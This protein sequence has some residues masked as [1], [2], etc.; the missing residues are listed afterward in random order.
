[1]APIHHF[2]GI[3]PAPGKEA[4]LKEVMT[5]FADKVEKQE[6]GVLKFH[7]FEQF[8]GEK[9]NVII[10]H[11]VYED[12]AAL[13]AHLKTEHFAAVKKTFAEEGLLAG[14]Y[15]MKKVKAFGGYRSR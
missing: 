8:D 14:R 11:E 1:M 2:A 5:E 9:G 3:N 15:E 4:R 10:V 13:E 7:L 12:D 6:Q